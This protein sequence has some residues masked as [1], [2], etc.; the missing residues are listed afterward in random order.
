[1]A[2]EYSRELSVKVFA[3][4]CRLIG[5][6]FRQGG[7]AGYALRRQLIDEHRQ[8]KCE[9]AIGTQKSL[10][11]DRVVL[12]PGP[13]R[14]VDNVRR[15]YR[16]FAEEGHSE[17]AIAATLNEEHELTD[18]NRL[19]T[20]GS[21]HQ[22]LTNEKYVGNNLYNRTSFKL[23]QKHV[24]NPPDMWIRADAAFRSIVDGKIYITSDGGVASVFKAGPQFELLAANKMD[25]YT[26]SS[27][28]IKDGQLFLHTSSA[29][30][31]IRT[32][33]RGWQIARCLLPSAFCRGCWRLSC[34]H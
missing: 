28:A 14:E 32:P 34:R 31:A 24:V 25:D 5:L 29:L 11:T 20:R 23:K 12:I 27:V 3:G 8:P 15:M 4:Q 21:V 19:W 30:W 22:V 6:G 26:L 1:M 17:Q 2:G 13:A 10:Q 16:L 7:L 9:L 18:L 33:A